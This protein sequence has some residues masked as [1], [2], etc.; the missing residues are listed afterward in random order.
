MNPVINQSVNQT[1]SLAIFT[2]INIPCLIR[3]FMRQL[4]ANDD[5]TSAIDII[6]KSR[7]SHIHLSLKCKYMLSTY[8]LNWCNLLQKSILMLL[9][10][11]GA[12]GLKKSIP[13]ISIK[14]L[15]FKISH[16]L[17]FINVESLVTRFL[18]LIYRVDVSSE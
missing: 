15:H 13:T 12:I 10:A 14:D 7:M 2:I 1:C 16:N 8:L 3:R 9:I 4:I 18:Q 5:I 6:D 17:A 11:I